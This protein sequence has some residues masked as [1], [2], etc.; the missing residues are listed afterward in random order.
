MSKPLT[1]TTAATVCLAVAALGDE[2]PTRIMIFAAG[3]TIR[4]RDGRTYRIDL[5]KLAARF[6]ADGVK[7]PLDVNHSTEI[8]APRGERADPVGWVTAVELAGAALFG[9]VEWI[10]PAG[11]TKLLRTYPYVSPAF[12]A[13]KG[14]AEWLKSIALVASPA[15]GNQPA[16]AAADPEET[17]EPLMKTVLAALGLAETASE[18]ECLAAV[19]ALN[20]RSADSVPK[21]VHDATLATLAAT[22]ADLDAIRAAGRKAEIDGLIEGALKAKKILPAQRDH[23]TALCATDAGLAS[24]KAL[25]EASPVLLGASGLDDK[26]TPGSEVATLSAEDRVVMEQL[27]ISEADFR[28]AN[29]LPKKP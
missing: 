17:Q 6:A 7:I 11:A 25:I 19:T 2:P 3:G 8:L 18:A 5:A 26:P 22:T 21:A 16:L 10:D 27:G 28:E 4:T 12:P 23:Y 20:V 9:T 13:P 24:V 14:E 15:L 29:G 1:A